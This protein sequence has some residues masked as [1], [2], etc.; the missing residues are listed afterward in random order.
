LIFFKSKNLK[1][2]K[3]KKYKKPYRRRIRK[4][5]QNGPTRPTHTRC[6]GV[7]RAASADLVGI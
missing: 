5:K 1:E 4:E 3:N 6:G 7:R 2:I